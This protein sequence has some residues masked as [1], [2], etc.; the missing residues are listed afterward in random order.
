MSGLSPTQQKRR[1][2]GIGGSDAGAIMGVSPWKS[3]V[4][5][6]LDKLGLTESSPDNK[7]THWGRKLE[8]IVAKEYAERTGYKLSKPRP[9]KH[10]ERPWMMASL[11]NM[12]TTPNDENRLVEVKT[13]N[14]Y[15]TDKW[16][17]EGTDDVPEEYLLQC[18]HYMV[19]TGVFV[20][21]IPV[22]IGGQD[23]RIYTVEYEKE[24]ADMLIKRESEFWHNHVLKK[25]PPPPMSGQD[26]ETLY[27]IDN[28]LALMATE[29]QVKRVH[30][31]RDLKRTIKDLGDR[32]VE[33]KDELKIVLG[34]N[35]ALVDEDNKALVTWKRS[36]DSRKFNAKRLKEE[37]PD[38]H[39]QFMDTTP[40][41]R[42][43]LV[44]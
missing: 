15:M 13:A 32:E 26:V 19:V 10:A 31:L 33:L 40:G 34:E 35:T 44:K 18:V 3:P 5:V 27:A 37:E 16:G 39:E 43:F 38:I 42:R 14:Q 25:I 4:D 2:K 20:V 9:V 7:A 23:F 6:Y 29:D 41:S 28:G 1:R 24:L 36:K 30:E 21:D 8:R 22:L 11:D 12:A 17:D